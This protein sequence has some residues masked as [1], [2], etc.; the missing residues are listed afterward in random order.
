MSAEPCLHTIRDWGGSQSKELR[1]SHYP[2]IQFN[3]WLHKQHTNLTT[4]SAFRPFFLD[5][6]D[7]GNQAFGDIAKPQ[8]TSSS[9]AAATPPP[10]FFSQSLPSTSAHHVNSKYESKFDIFNGGSLDIL[11]SHY[12]AGHC[13]LADYR[14]LWS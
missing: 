8:K 5:K 10:Q 1:Y 12:P 13:E 4:Y 9:S 11:Q 6:L 7:T 14:R 2:P 3:S